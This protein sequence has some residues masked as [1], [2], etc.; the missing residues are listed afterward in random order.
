MI[1]IRR[2]LGPAQLKAMEIVNAKNPGCIY[3]TDLLAAMAM[4]EVGW[5]LAEFIASGLKAKAIWPIMRG[6]YSQREGEKEKSYHGYGPW[7]IDIGSYPQ[8]VK[9]GDWKDPVKCC[10]KALEVLEEK[11]RYLVERF[12]DLKDHDLLLAVVCSYNAGQGNISK[13]LRGEMKNKKGEVVTDVNYPTHGRDYGREVFRFRDLYNAL[14][15]PSP[16]P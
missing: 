11:R 3:T 12:P 6:D 15:E 9:S 4:R 10:V 7:Q 16:E 5:K 8:F 14:P 1:W 2:E 13:V